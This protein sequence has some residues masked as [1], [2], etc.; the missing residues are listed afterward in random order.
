MRTIQ[1]P[2]NNNSKH[3][4]QLKRHVTIENEEK[5]SKSSIRETELN[6]FIDIDVG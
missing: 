3:L 5:A 6:S 2:K 1:S 4:L